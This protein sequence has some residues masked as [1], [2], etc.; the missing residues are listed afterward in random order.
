MDHL[1]TL[2]AYLDCAAYS[3]FN[4]CRMRGGAF[5]LFGLRRLFRIQRLSHAL[6]PLF[7]GLSGYLHRPRVGGVATSS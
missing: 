1:I 3:A 7:G 2:F 6:L 4:L 5:A